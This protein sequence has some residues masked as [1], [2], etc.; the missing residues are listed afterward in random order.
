MYDPAHR[1][2]RRPASGPLPSGAADGHGKP[3]APGQAVASYAVGGDRIHVTVRGELDL[4]SG[5]LLRE[6]L[7]RALAAS[8]GGLDLD[9]SRLGFCDCAGLHVLLE[10]RRRALGQG[11]TVVIQAGGPAIDRLL[12]LLGCRELFAPAGSRRPELRHSAPAT[13]HAPKAA[14]FRG[15][16]SARSRTNLAERRRTPH[17]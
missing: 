7:H 14:T 10:L 5:N 1:A 3:L 2:E 13:A 15:V 11:K 4:E 9:L 12:G 6:D 17:T 8:S 16:T